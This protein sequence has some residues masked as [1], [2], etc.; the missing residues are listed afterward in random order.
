MPNAVSDSIQGNYC[1][2]SP[3]T[4]SDVRS[5]KL[6]ASSF[7]GSFKFEDLMGSPPAKKRIVESLLIGSGPQRQLKGQARSQRRDGIAGK[8]LF[9]HSRGVSS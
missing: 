5:I 3:I 9:G 7:A 1:V 6:Q 2:L 4:H 8:S